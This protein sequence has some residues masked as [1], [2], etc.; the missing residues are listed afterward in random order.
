MLILPS[1]NCWIEHLDTGLWLWGS[2][3]F[4][5]CYY[6]L[7]FFIFLSMYVWIHSPFLSLISPQHTCIRTWFLLVYHLHKHTL[8]HLL[9]SY[10][11]C[12]LWPVQTQSKTC[13]KSA[14]VISELIF[15]IKDIFLKMTADMH[16][17]NCGMKS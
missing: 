13:C 15:L 12:L 11:V 4:S 17:L 5:R 3:I 14:L 6:S 2:S 10:K 8:L 7:S 1:L 16:K 9:I